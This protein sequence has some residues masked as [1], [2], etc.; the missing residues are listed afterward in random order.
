MFLRSLFGTALSSLSDEELLTAARSRRKERY[1]DEI[2]R[3]YHVE[4]YGLCLYYLRE[5]TASQDMTLVVFSKAFAELPSAEVLRLRPWL[6][7]LTRHQCINQLHKSKRRLA[8]QT[9]WMEEAER[10]IGW[11]ENAGWLRLR[12]GEEIPR[13]DR[14]LQHLDTLPAE[15]QQCLKLFYWREMSYRQIAAA[16]GYPEKRVKSYLQNGKRQ[17]RLALLD[18]GPADE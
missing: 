6:L 3:R 13:A 9:A 4:V 16:T 7:S 12:A 5:T 1:F 2:F 8:D 10:Q 11:T 17:L 14:L 18:Q 15:Q